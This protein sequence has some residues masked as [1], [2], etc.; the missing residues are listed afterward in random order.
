MFS[1]ERN[2]DRRGAT[3]GE[4]DTDKDNYTKDI[5]SFHAKDRLTIR[6]DL[7]SAITTMQET[8]LSRIILRRRRCDAQSSR[9]QQPRISVTMRFATSWRRRAS[10]KSCTSRPADL[11]LLIREAFLHFREYLVRRTRLVKKLAQSLL[12]Q[13]A[14]YLR[15]EI[16]G[17]ADHDNIVFQFFQSTEYFRAAEL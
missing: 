9:G 16:A 2:V 3:D 6:G 17:D 8:F 10:S 7:I 14:F 1:L 13:P 15:I 12:K 4:E 5:S 11:T